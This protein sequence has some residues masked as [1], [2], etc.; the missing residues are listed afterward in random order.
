MLRLRDF[1]TLGIFFSGI[2]GFWGFGFWGFGVLGFW[3]FGGLGVWRFWGLGDKA[4]RTKPGPSDL[5]L[6]DSQAQLASQNLYESVW[7][8]QFFFWG[9]GGGSLYFADFEF[10]GP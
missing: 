4:H 1:L 5:Q 3:G 6:Q 8:P 7:N 10:T 2:W 9:G